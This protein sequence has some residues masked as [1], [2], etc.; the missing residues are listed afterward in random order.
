MA[1]IGQSLRRFED[2]RLLTGASS[3]VDDLQLP[4]MLHAPV[5]RSPY[6]HALIK[7]IDTAGATPPN[8]VKSAWVNAAHPRLKAR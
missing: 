2:Q 3:Y 6:A 8:G 4:G 5:L 7:G 1:Y